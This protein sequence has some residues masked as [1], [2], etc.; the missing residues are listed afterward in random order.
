MRKCAFVLGLFFAFGG[1][2]IVTD[3]PSGALLP[4][5]PVFGETP[6]KSETSKTSKTSAKKKKTKKSGGTSGK[7]DS[8]LTEKD[9]QEIGKAASDA[10][11]KAGFGRTKKQLPI[12]T[13]VGPVDKK[14]GWGVDEYGT[15]IPNKNGDALDKKL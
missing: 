5:S 15:A 10:L 3:L 11:V 6:A 9:T 14:T 8:A 7:N 2:L 1:S 4:I 13:S 12:G